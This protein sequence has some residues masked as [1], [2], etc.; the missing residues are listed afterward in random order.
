MKI[1]VMFGNPE[2]TTGGNALKFYSSVRLDI[3]RIESIKEG[4][5]VMGSRVRVKVV[6]N[7][8]APPFK[9]AEFDVMFAEGISKVGE[10]VDLGVD[11]RIIDKAGAW[12]S[13]KEERLGQGREAVKNFLKN[14]PDVAETI[15]NQIRQSFGL[16]ANPQGN[17]PS[18]MSRT[19]SKK[20]A[21]AKN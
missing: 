19:D 16:V 15:S 21:S 3:R 12:Y 2:T 6:K 17:Q 8:M 11:R 10:L 1:G 14:N 4:Q 18:T 5:D 7:K 13:Y 20:S 9:Q